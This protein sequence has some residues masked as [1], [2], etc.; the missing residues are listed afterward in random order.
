MERIIAA[1][2][3]VKSE[4]QCKKDSVYQTGKKSQM[5]FTNVVLADTMP[6]SCIY[7]AS[8]L[9]KILMVFTPLMV[10]GLTKK[11]LPK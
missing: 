4:F 9:T 2:Y 7:G 3:K 8:K 11:K 10:D 6:K 5:I 1:A